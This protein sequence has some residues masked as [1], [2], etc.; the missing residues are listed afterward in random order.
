MAVQI[1][2]W[3]AF[4]GLY[5]ALQGATGRTPGK[6]VFGLKV[7]NEQG[8]NP[9][10]GRGLVRTLLW[11]VDGQPCGIPL[12]GFITGLTTKGHRRVGDMAA[13]TF[14]VGKAHSGPV[15]VPGL[16][17]AALSPYGRARRSWR[18]RRPVGCPAGRRPDRP[19]GVLR[20]SRRRRGAAQPSGGFPPPGASGPPAGA[21]APVRGARRS[22]GPRRCRDRR[23]RRPRP[24]APRRGARPAGRRPRARRPPARPLP[25]LPPATRR[26]RRGPRGPRADRPG[27]RRGPGAGV[28]PDGRGQPGDPRPARLRRNRH[29]SR[30]RS[31]PATGYNPQWDAARGTYI[32]WEPQRGQWL[33]WDDATKQWRPL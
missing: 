22:P 33:G 2:T 21:A 16:T 31:R 17:T 18:T 13:K 15:V 14:V 24:R 26:R 27:G 32:V 7:V 4:V 28:R 29:H 23:P 5:A 19:P 10:F 12:V 20:P 8:G 11:I 3:V 6:A 1:V 25:P 9:G 30:R